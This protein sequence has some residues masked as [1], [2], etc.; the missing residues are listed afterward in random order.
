MCFKFLNVQVPQMFLDVSFRMEGLPEL[1]CGIVLHKTCSY[2]DADGSHTQPSGKRHSLFHS[3][4]HM[5]VD[6]VARVPTL[7]QA[8]YLRGQRSSSRRGMGNF[9]E[10][11]NI[12]LQESQTQVKSGSTGEEGRATCSFPDGRLPSHTLRARTTRPPKIQRESRAPGRQR[13]R[14]QWVQSSIH[15]ARSFSIANGSKISGYIVQIPWH[16]W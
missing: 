1:Q 11:T 13:Q 8:L 2:S 6:M 9:E 3:I 15:G 7:F 14:R 10:S 16:E 5:S 12:G 4:H